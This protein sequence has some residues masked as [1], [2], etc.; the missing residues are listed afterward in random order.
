MKILHVSSWLQPKLGYSEYHLP[1]AQQRLGHEVAVLTSDRYYPFPDYEST[2]GLVL[3]NR[4]VGIGTRRELDLTVF[5][6]PILFEYRHHLWLR[7][8]RRA[9]A[10]YKPDV[11][12]VHEAF[13]LPAVQSALAKSKFGYV[14]VVA[15]SMEPEVFYPQT[16]ARAAYYRL[17]RAAAAP[18][19]RRRVDAFSAV[20]PGARKI[21]SAQLRVAE[22]NIAVVPLGADAE[23]FC[24]DQSRRDDLRR[25][26]GVPD[27]LVLVVYAGKLIPDKDVHVLA[28]AFV[29][30][31][32]TAKCG[33]L[34]V[35]NGPPAYLQELQGILSGTPRPVFFAGA[36]PNRELAGYFD[37]ADIG[38]WPSQSSN[39]AIEAAL[40]GLPLIVSESPAT[41]HYISGGNGLN[42]PRGDAVQLAARLASL[43]EQPALR[44]KMAAD[45]RIYLEKTMSWKAV[46]HRYIEMY[47][48]AGAPLNRLSGGGVPTM[49][50]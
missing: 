47:E 36:V 43:A 18:W 50:P 42:F 39:A 1:I 16:A 7:G 10:D 35:G 26:L 49:T 2:V 24:P 6:R 14:L 21:L 13:T 3:G 5:R 46:A 45:G 23:T 37:G 32:T 12:H 4:I 9:L 28:R 15:S 25:R 44:R 27:D 34:L 20:G 8:F 38:V 11:V 31:S 30:M 48:R 17:H 40:C 41:T 29:Q 22:D 33:L 19:L